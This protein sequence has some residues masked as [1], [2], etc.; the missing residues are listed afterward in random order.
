MITKEMIAQAQKE[1]KANLKFGTIFIT[2]AGLI[3]S[4]TALYKFMTA[5]VN[6]DTI[7]FHILF[8]FGGLITLFGLFSA[9][10][11]L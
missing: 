3:L 7:P 6:T 4:A 1:R 2:T 11:T 9:E 10:K 8:S 5:D